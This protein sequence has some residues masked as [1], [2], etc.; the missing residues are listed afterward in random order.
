MYFL[1][2]LWKWVLLVFGGATTARTVAKYAAL[3]LTAAVTFLVARGVSLNI[4][5][6]VT[7]AG[8]SRQILD[9]SEDQAYWAIAAAAVFAVLL[10]VTLGLKQARFPPPRLKKP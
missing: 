1:S 10:L 6:G 9:A 3:I 7:L 4:S 5:V 2:V 8:E